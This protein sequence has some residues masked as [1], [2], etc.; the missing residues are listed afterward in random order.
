M[1]D[2]G[3]NSPQ[4]SSVGR[5]FD[6]VAALTGIKS[7][8]TF[9]AEAAVALESE[10]F[11]SRAG[12]CYKY[13][14][15]NGIISMYKPIKAVLDDLKKGVLPATVSARFHNTVTD[16]IVSFAK[17][18]KVKSIV[19]G[20][21]VFQNIYLLKKTRDRLLSSG[22]DIYYNKQVPVNDGG[23]CLGQAFLANNC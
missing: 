9:E 14:I 21:G 15:D 8:S 10:A 19:L 4:S 3:V 5:I 2:S 23:I 6:A 22:F 12:S 16:I 18:Q 11:G 17:K 20:G 1:I 13:D 7:I